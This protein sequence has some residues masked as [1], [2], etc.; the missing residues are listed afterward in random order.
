MNFYVARVLE[1]TQWVEIQKYFFKEHCYCGFTYVSMKF[2]LIL[3]KL[4][5]IS[6]FFV[7]TAV[8]T[9]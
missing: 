3:G 1:T 9:Q 7:K 4:E 2:F 5:K 8:F 6:L